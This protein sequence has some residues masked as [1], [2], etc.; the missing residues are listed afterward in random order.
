MS[1]RKPRV[2]LLRD[3]NLHGRPVKAGDVAE[4]DPAFASRLIARGAAEQVLTP[5]PV[6]AP[7]VAP[8]SA[9]KSKGKKGNTE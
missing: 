5:E 9:P 1:I 8:E 6:P 4:V 3:G 2:K 7:A